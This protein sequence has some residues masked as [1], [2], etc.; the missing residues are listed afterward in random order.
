MR[1]LKSIF[2]SIIIFSAVFGFVFPKPVSFAYTPGQVVINEVAWA[3]TEDGSSDEWIELYNNS[4]QSVDLSGWKIVDD[5]VDTYTITSGVVAAKGYFLIE[6]SEPTVNTIAADSVIGISLSNT[7][8]SLV[9][10]DSSDNV[11]DTVNST[12]GT[13]FAGNSTTKS[14]MERIDPGLV[15]DTA[16]NWASATSGNSSLGRSGSAIF[17]TPK[18]QNS[19]FAGN[20][21]KAIM[22]TTSSSFEKDSFVNILINIEGA[23]DIYAYGFEINYNPLILD[24]QN[25]NEGLF[26]KKDGKSTSFLS[27]LENNQEGKLI[28]GNTRLENPPTGVSGDGELYSMSFKIIG[29]IGQST[30]LQFGAGSYISDIIGVTPANFGGMTITVGESA[31]T[32]TEAVTNL[33]ISLGTEL[34]SLELSWNSITGGADKYLI[35]RKNQSGNFDLIGE[36]QATTF[37]DNDTLSNGGKIIPNINYVYRVIAVKN[38]IQSQELEVT[39][40]DN[41]GLTGDNDRSKR[42]DGKDLERLARSYGEIYGNTNY[43]ALKDTNYD[44]IIDGSD[45]IDIGANFGLVYQQL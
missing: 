8:D 33:N 44:G 21:L 38:N 42:V 29:N 20:S 4:S 14:T 30:D 31:P 26:L 22:T 34:Y 1:I 40:T 41:R 2:G 39:G 5:G 16:A 43:D 28:V 23:S 15:G 27:A 18:G 9:L 35:Y 32:T 13:W 24:Y 37:T 36:T 3:G 11:I 19:T 10:K 6:D 45:L 12:S 17:G 7:G 25:S